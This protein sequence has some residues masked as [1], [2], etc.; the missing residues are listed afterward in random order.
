MMN[1]SAEVVGRTALDS[2][3]ETIKTV[4]NYT[5]RTDNS[6]SNNLSASFNTI[7]N[8]GNNS[9]SSCKSFMRPT[10]SS[11]TKYTVR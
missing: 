6:N 9:K 5:R 10:K 4:P 7:E 2:T 1:A 3:L 11:R 8:M